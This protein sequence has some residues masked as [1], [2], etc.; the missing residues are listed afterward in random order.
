MKQWCLLLAFLLSVGS[1]TAQE[2]DVSDS[3]MV[4]G[5]VVNRMSGLPEPFSVVSL[6]QG[7]Q[8]VATTSCD[9]EG[10]FNL[11]SM[12][13]G[14]Y[15]LEVKLRGLTLYHADLVLQQNAE[16]NIGVITDS[17]RMVNL[18][19][20]EV[21]A[22]RHMLGSL[23]I[24]SKDNV[25]LWDFSY[26]EGDPIRDGNASVANPFSLHP[27]FGDGPCS[28]GRCSKYTSAY[29]KFYDQSFGLNVSPLNSAMKNDLLSNGYRY[30]RDVKQPAPADT[31]QGR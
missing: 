18:K 20:V 27:L 31:V 9:E 15:L 13:A 17:L 25:R 16:V 19:E 14:S 28:G 8:V 22:L 10:W 7:D 3:V 2:Y 12:P 21:L 11:P 6:L 26:R 29:G 30:I 5:S 23:Y 4:M 1:V 24:S